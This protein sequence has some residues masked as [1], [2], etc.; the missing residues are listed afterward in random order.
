[1][2]LHDDLVMIQLTGR[3]MENIVVLLIKEDADCEAFYWEGPF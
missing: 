2:K 1:M 3:E